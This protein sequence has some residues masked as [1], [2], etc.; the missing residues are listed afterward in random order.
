MVLKMKVHKNKKSGYCHVFKWSR[1]VRFLASKTRTFLLPNKGFTLIE[2]LIT[3]LLIS[4]VSVS[5][6]NIYMLS[7][8]ITG[9]AKES[10]I[11]N[12]LAQTYIED[13]KISPIDN[14]LFDKEEFI[15]EEIID[16][17]NVK[18]SIKS[19]VKKDCNH[20]CNLYKLQVVVT[21]DNCRCYIVTTKVGDN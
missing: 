21:K 8:K 12:S 5:L 18:K 15:S 19:I 1:K 11:V 16:G 2:S 3:V 4:I 9:V 14:M 10:L 17:F 6:F 20:L 7:V 13:L